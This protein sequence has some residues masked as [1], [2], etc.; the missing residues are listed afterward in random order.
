MNRRIMKFDILEV[1]VANHSE[2]HYD[3]FNCSIQPRI[4]LY[5]QIKYS[6]KIG[7]RALTNIVF[8]TLH[9]QLNI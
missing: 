4:G 2:S 8:K 1:K 9:V 7:I 3:E 5:T 6:Y